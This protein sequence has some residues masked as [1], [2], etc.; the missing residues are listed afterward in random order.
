[1]FTQVHAV[2]NSLSSDFICGSMA[3]LGEGSLFVEI[4]K[5]DV[6]SDKRA[7][8]AVLGSHTYSVLD[9]AALVPSDPSWYHHQVLKLLSRRTSATTVHGL[10]MHVFSMVGE[11]QSA[12]RLLSKGESVGKVVVQV[13]GMHTSS[14]LELDAVDL[15]AA[16]DRHSDRAFE[17]LQADLSL[18]H[19]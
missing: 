19:I 9:M 10:P 6:W 1:M 4:G 8:A 11:V 5:R 15:F 18:I 3:L 7:T 14:P 2:L 17:A 12:F 16:L 13:S